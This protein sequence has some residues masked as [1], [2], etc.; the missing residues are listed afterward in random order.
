MQR[1]Q[2][3]DGCS[4]HRAFLLFSVT[5]EAIVKSTIAQIMSLD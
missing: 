2:G 3:A 1:A 4:P 5:T